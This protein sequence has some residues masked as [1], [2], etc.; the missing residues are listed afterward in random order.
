VRTRRRDLL[1]F[2]HKFGLQAWLVSTFGQAMVKLKFARN[3]GGGRVGMFGPK[4]DTGSEI[5]VMMNRSLV[6][7]GFVIGLSLVAGGCQ[8]LSPQKPAELPALRGSEGIDRDAYSKLGYTLG[9]SGFAGI[10]RSNGAKVFRAVVADDLV[11]VQDNKGSVS[12]L[13][14]SS[15]QLVWATQVETAGADFMGLARD[16]NRVIAATQSEVFVLDAES[17][18]QLS[19]QRLERSMSSE[20]VMIS[21][22]LVYGSSMGAAAAHQT[23]A[24]F[25]AWQYTL[26][27][28]V[29]APATRVDATGV[30]I[31]TGSGKVSV[32]DASTGTL[33]GGN[34]MFDRTEGKMA[35]G[36]GAVY[37]ASL[38]QSL[39][40]FSTRNGLKLW[41]VRS[42]VPLTRGPYVVSTGDGAMV[43]VQ[44]PGRGL[45]AVDGQTGAQR[46]LSKEVSGDVV[47]VKGKQLVTF[48]AVS[49][50]ASTIDPSTGKVVSSVT[51]ERVKHFVQGS[52]QSVYVVSNE[53]EVS[54]FN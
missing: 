20:P 38:D 11:L 36:D 34:R 2:G 45:L 43:L 9:W 50:V 29:F 12:A 53:G 22:L 40:A 39:Y 23:R 44:M 35:A 5:S 28:P 24:G 15:G 14:A 42:D 1:C 26:D 25:S 49:N 4:H 30:A 19:R 31:S 32:F 3:L 8:H 7:V 6:Q 27:G 13:K 48:D 17:G 51:L 33:R 41:Q 37:V 54:R 47:A 52:G 16:G 21:G 10:D 18:V 46:W